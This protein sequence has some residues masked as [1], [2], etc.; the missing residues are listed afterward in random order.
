M[1]LRIAINAGAAGGFRMASAE[2]RM[3]SA[4]RFATEDCSLYSVDISDKVQTV[5]ISMKAKAGA[6]VVADPKKIAE[7][8][9]PRTKDP[10]LRVCR[11]SPT[12]GKW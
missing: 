3:A 7:A 8:V 4:E 6:S 2:L 12:T 5:A 11:R 10:I 9:W 1:T